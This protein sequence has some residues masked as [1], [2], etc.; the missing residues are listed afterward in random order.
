MESSQESSPK[1]FLDDVL[2][3]TVRVMSETRGA[4]VTTVAAT[5]HKDSLHEWAR[6]YSKRYPVEGYMTKFSEITEEAG[7]YS[8]RVWRMA[9]CD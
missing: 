7:V 2:V 4:T 8:L 6:Y 9:S 5:A 1:N 3:T